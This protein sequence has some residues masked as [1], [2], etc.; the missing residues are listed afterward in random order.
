M[1]AHSDAQT[2]TATGIGMPPVP[3]AASGDSV[4]SC[5]VLR[6]PT[7]SLCHHRKLTGMRGGQM[8]QRRLGSLPTAATS[9]VRTQRDHRLRIGL[10]ISLITLAAT[11]VA[12]AIWGPVYG[13]FGW[14]VVAIAT[15]WMEALL[16]GLLIEGLRP[17]NPYRH[18]DPRLGFL[19]RPPTS[20][21]QDADTTDLWYIVPGVCLSL[22]LLLSFAVI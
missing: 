4:T 17:Q 21:P 6:I 7:E 16:L 11:G 15:L 5:L 9:G 19:D 14:R 12:V 10:L 2:R 13:R 1:G 8:S 20:A 18:L 22:L 3:L